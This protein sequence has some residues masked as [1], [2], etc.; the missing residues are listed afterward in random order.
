M[1]KTLYVSDLDGTLLDRDARLSEETVE[2]LNRL[3][4]HEAVNFTIATARTPATVTGIMERVSTRLPFV[5]LNGAATWDN[6]ER[7][8]L[9]VTPL[10]N[11]TVEQVCTIF[12]KHDLRPLIYRRCGN[13]IE[14]HHNGELSRQEMQFV[15]ERLN[16]PLKRFCLNDAD[17]MCG[18][19]DAL[20]I[21]SMNDYSR[22]KPVYMEVNAAVRCSS[23]FY[24]DISDSSAGL[25]ETYAS[26]VSKAVA[27][28][29]LAESIG[30]ERLVVFGDNRND[31]P[32]MK[33]ADY[34]V[35][36]ANAVDEVKDVADEV[37]EPNYMHSVAKFIEKDCSL[38][39]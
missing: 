28:R 36:P 6:A 17:Y 15:E 18:E 19:G 21:F 20:L 12:E 38:P 11:D 3:I 24:H 22:L 2:I 1:K 8:F 31:I 25:M 10:D 29:R 23:V 33:V 5:V 7:R 27:V 39:R 9:T 26:G 30:A 32:M 35:A 13:M 37:I 14:V 34:A 16:L 4:R